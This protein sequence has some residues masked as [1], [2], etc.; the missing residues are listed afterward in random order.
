MN[1]TPI[2]PDDLTAFALG[3]FDADQASRIAERMKQNPAL[4]EQVESIRR[5]AVAITDALKSSA[6]SMPSLSGEHHRNIQHALEQA[7]S[8]THQPHRQLWLPVSIAAVIALLIGA[9]VWMQ[10]GDQSS[11]D[12]IS[13]PGPPE[14][15]GLNRLEIE[16]PNPVFA[17]TPKDIPENV[18]IDRARHGKPREP[19]YVPAG[20][21]DISLNK[22]VTS[23]DPY[24]IIGDLDL[25]TDGDKE[26][27]DGRFVELAP[28]K[29]W[30][31][32]DLEKPQQIY[33]VVIWHNHL[34]PRVY[35]DV[36]VQLSDNPTFKSGVKT[37]FNNDDDNS[38]GFGVGR[39][40]EYFES[41]EGQLVRID[42]ATGRYVRLWSS[43]STSDDQNHYTEVQVFGREPKP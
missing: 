38:S 27:L 5:T 41:F 36:V 42:G 10:M 32:I 28:G 17:G 12:R 2:K 7:M 23:S 29:Q 37:V 39:D 33:A 24:P 14:A 11:S 16:L 1:D 34:D 15:Y 35:R 6:E 22:P 30:V 13:E 8:N 21:H 26:A 20:M 19:F 40:Y 31:Q 3:E 18:N 4:A 25:I 43:G 9:A